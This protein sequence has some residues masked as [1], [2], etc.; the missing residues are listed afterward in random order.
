MTAKTEFGLLQFQNSSLRRRNMKGTESM[1][2]R[3]AFQDAGERGKQ[4]SLTN[5]ICE[6]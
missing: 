1:T 5:V 2:Q 6:I 4:S 3:D